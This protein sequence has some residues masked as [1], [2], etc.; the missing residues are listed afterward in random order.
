M[1]ERINRI[2]N[3]NI[4]A[5]V[6]VG[7]AREHAGISNALSDSMTSA[8]LVFAEGKCLWHIALY[9]KMGP[10]SLDA[11]AEVN[12]FA[13][14]YIDAQN[15]EVFDYVIIQPTAYD[16]FTEQSIGR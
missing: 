10:Y 4:D 8:G 5:S 7:I 1:S 14:Y 16:L 2:R 9:Q 13:D 6:A 15:G 11:S 3:A 12:Q